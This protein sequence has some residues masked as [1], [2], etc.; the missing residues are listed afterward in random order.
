[1]EREEEALGP[2]A[3]GLKSSASEL[4]VTVVIATSLQGSQCCKLLTVRRGGQWEKTEDLEEGVV[5]DQRLT[6]L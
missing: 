1:M 4:F 2:E 3:L 6:F 5:C